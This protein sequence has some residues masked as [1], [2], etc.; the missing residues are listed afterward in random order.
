MAEPILIDLTHVGASGWDGVTTLALTRNDLTVSGQRVY[1]AE[2][3]SGGV[4]L[5]DVFG[6]FH[7]ESFKLVSVAAKNHTPASF[8]RVGPRGVDETVYRQEYDLVP[9]FQSLVMAPTDTLR[10]FYPQENPASVEPLTVTLLIN[11]LSEANA[12]RMLE[13]YPEAGSHRRYRLSRADV[14]VATPGVAINP[15]WTYDAV[16][17]TSEANVATQ[18]TISVS[19]LANPQSQGVYAWFRFTG[20]VAGSGSVFGVDPRTQEQTT[21]AGPLNTM[22][23]SKGVWLSRDDLLTFSCTAATGAGPA[24]EIEVSPRTSR[25]VFP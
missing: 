13:Q 19:D 11:D 5:G 23:W 1:T 4:I 18:G 25:I 20:I 6:L 10:I 8:V 12:I 15:S 21:L 2:I 7:A 9:N 16:T 17:R 22:V 14:F 3:D 24:V